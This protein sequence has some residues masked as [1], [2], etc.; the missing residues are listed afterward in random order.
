MMTI[1]QCE[2]LREP[3]LSD[4]TF[5]GLSQ[6]ELG[7]ATSQD[8]VRIRTRTFGV[9]SGP[10]VV[11]IHGFPDFWLTWRALIPHLVNQGY[12][13]CA[14]DLRGYNETDA[15]GDDEAYRPERLVEDVR[16]VVQSRGRAEAIIVG[17][18]WGGFVAWKTAMLAPELVSCLVVLNMP[19]PDLLSLA[20][21][22]D[23][24][25]AEIGAYARRFQA[26]SGDE[27]PKAAL[28]QWVKDEV[29]RPAYGEAIERS[30]VRAMLAY[31]RVNYPTEPYQAALDLTPLRV[32]APTLMIYGLD[33]PYLL[34]GAIDGV[35]GYVDAPFTLQAVPGAGHFVQHDAPDEVRS[36]ITGWLSRTSTRTKA[37]AA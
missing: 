11:L 36:A 25:Q 34:A 27:I 7:F 8:G 19:H 24:R 14:I 18:D 23:P 15:P 22:R 17:H 28:L 31:Y 2:H 4:F 1:M 3:A 37:A 33:D 35:W 29:A 6:V 5:L 13:V 32:S 12:E 21:A 26:M 16:A 30:D 10:L 20:Y 9:G